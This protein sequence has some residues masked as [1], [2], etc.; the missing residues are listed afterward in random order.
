MSAIHYVVFPDGTQ[1]DI[2]NKAFILKHRDC[3]PGLAWGHW[4]R[5][6]KRR[7]DPE[8]LVFSCRN[9]KEQLHSR[10]QHPRHGV[11]P[12]VGLPY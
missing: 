4:Y 5:V 9:C 2:T 11:D 7:T 12:K 6:M 10:I 3:K 1:K 8:S